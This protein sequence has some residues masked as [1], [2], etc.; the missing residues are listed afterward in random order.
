MNQEK[1]SG[2]MSIENH[3]H[4]DYNSVLQY[5]HR[6]L[7]ASI[8]G[9]APDKKNL[10]LFLL[11]TLLLTFFGKRKVS[12]STEC[13]P[14]GHHLISMQT[15]LIMHGWTLGQSTDWLCKAW[16]QG[17]RGTIGGLSWSKL[18]HNTHTHTHT[19]THTSLLT[20]LWRWYQ[21]TKPH[22]LG[23]ITGMIEA[24]HI[25]NSVPTPQGLHVATVLY[26]IPF[27]L[28]NFCHFQSLLMKHESSHDEGLGR[29]RW[30]AC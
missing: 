16:I 2:V 3:N 12:S 27:F 17:L 6:A 15:H 20:L 30:E 23:H 25:I 29:A 8:A 11:G 21:T 14:I 1:E 7:N 4:I 26:T 18:I 13:V 19:H 10:F 22:A 24:C 9:M 28:H 5:T